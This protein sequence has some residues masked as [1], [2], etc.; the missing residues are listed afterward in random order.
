MSEPTNVVV[1]VEEELELSLDIESLAVPSNK[2]GERKTVLILSIGAIVFN[3]NIVQTFD[4]MMLNQHQFYSPIS[5]GDSLANGFEFDASTLGFWN[6]QAVK[7]DGYNMIAEAAAHTE[8]VSLTLARL[9]TFLKSQKL[10]RAWARSP[11]FDCVI[12][13]EAMNKMGL[14]FP[15]GPFIERDVRTLTDLGDID[16]RQKPYGYR[17]H[18]ALDDAAV[19]AMHVQQFRAQQRDIAFKLSKLEFYENQH[20]FDMRWPEFINGAWE[21]VYPAKST[22]VAK[23]PVPRKPRVPKVKVALPDVPP[24]GNN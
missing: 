21:W 22:K 13:K 5:L 16:I 12:I 9:E 2:P 3:P 18:H 10:K 24:E 15:I 19:E 1:A 8:L 6:K 23:E 17:A 11:V 14:T 7:E 4:E 20:V